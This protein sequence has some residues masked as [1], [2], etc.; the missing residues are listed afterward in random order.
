MISR[1]REK[2]GSAGLVLGVIAL[3]LALSGAAIAAK[4]GLTGKQKKEVKA[5]AKSF[6]GTGPAGPT[7]PVGAN[8]KDGANGANGQPGG[9]G[10]AGAT[11]KNGATG[12]NGTNGTNGVTGATGPTG[13]TGEGPGGGGPTGPTGATGV[14]G[15]TGEGGG[16]GFPVTLPSGK[17]ETGTWVLQGGGG[18]SA[19]PISFPIP[20]S[21]EDAAN[22]EVKL[23][24]PA[25]PSPSAACTGT[26]GNP[27]APA[28]TLCVYVLESAFE[29]EPPEVL[30]TVDF[31]NEGVGTNGAFIYHPTSVG[32][33]AVGSFA[34]T[35]P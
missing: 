30:S 20:L 14:T 33:Q 24:G 1:L 16:G 8:G 19:A 18:E 7:G 5:I 17:T 32:Q 13:P 4:G 9:A 28:G 26:T 35:A 10:A 27:T 12:A 25:V 11:G 6:Q 29:S 31:F 15:A 22:I 3:I 23:A 2:V 34:I 21:V